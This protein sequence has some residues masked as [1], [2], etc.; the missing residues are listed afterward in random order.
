MSI[1]QKLINFNEVFA[2][3]EKTPIIINDLRTSTEEEKLEL[4][5]KIYTLY[6][7]GVM[8]TVPSCECG[9][10]TGEYNVGITCKICNTDV[11]SPLYTDLE[12]ILWVRAPEG[13]KSLINPHVWFI[14][15][16]AFTISNFQL[17][18]WICDTTYN[19]SRPFKETTQ[20]LEMGVQRGY[21]FFLEN[22]D[23]VIEQLCQLK[24]FTKS[25]KIEN[26]EIV[27]Q[28]I[29]EYRDCLFCNY[30][31][32]P[33]RVLLVIE[34]TSMGRYVDY[35]YFS[36]ID[37]IQM[38]AS[39]DTVK[40]KKK[41][42]ANLVIENIS[43][44][45]ILG[46]TPEPEE[47]I[48]LSTGEISASPGLLTDNVSMKKKENR[49]VKMIS[50]LSNF[51]NNYNRNNLG[52]KQGMI[53]KH[54]ISSRNHFSFRTVISSITVPHVYDELHVPWGAAVGSLRYHILNKLSKQGMT[55]NQAI[56]F[57]NNYARRYHP[58]LDDIFKELIN[59]SVN[60]D[61]ETGIITNGIPCVLI[62]NPS[63]A[64]GSALKLRITQ[65]K[66]D[67]ETLT[68]SLSILSVVSL[69][70]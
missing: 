22:F 1:Y 50:A 38:I 9:K 58:K 68:M 42:K 41:K 6:E 18:R 3:L 19:E 63:L 31:P 39:I 17:I 29:K 25:P 21:N 32:L 60:I 45:K 27:L 5:K 13:V 16:K 67:P 64:R 59:E 12:P 14:L 46:Q 37:A 54:V 35:T 44:N 23:W 57:I 52:S 4:N 43:V 40:N 10:L 48:N 26:I 66:P 69:N 15:N 8:S 20:L 53:R 55:C 7:S 28:M 61:K 33:N 2:T 70:A 34:D 56:E 30:L 49:T 36:L 62:R 65:V 11:A 24:I 47:F 51:Y